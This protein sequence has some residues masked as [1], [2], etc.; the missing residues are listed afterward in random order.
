M[1]ISIALPT[2]KSFGRA[3]TS[4]PNN[5]VLYSAAAAVGVFGALTLHLT[6]KASSSE[7]S[8]EMQ[9]GSADGYFPSATPGAWLSNPPGNKAMVVGEDYAPP[10][11]RR[12]YQTRRLTKLNAERKASRKASKNAAKNASNTV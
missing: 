7:P 8:L 9:F 4:A 12:R 3:L 2:M 10:G 11:D 1:S 6:E 5:N